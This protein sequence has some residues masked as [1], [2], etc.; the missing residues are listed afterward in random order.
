M[1]DEI[2]IAELELSATIGVPDEERAKPQRLVLS[3]SMTPRRPFA[4][5]KDDVQRTVDYAAVAEAA[6]AFAAAHD[7]RLLETLGHDLAQHL[8]GNFAIDT[9]RLELRKFILPDTKYVAVSLA[10]EKPTNA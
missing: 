8:L 5:M 3:L 1:R 2:H 7:A 6:K 4:E 10:R 9:I